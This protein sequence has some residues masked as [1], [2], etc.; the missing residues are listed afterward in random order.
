[1]ILE[2]SANIPHTQA[3]S[4]VVVPLHHRWIPFPTPL[5]IGLNRP[6][7]PPSFVAPNVRLLVLN[8]FLYGLIVSRLFIRLTIAASGRNFISVIVNKPG[9]PGVAIAPP[10]L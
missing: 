1:M 10:A 5:L 3:Q 9:G 2:G 7:T 4:A 6:F 8:L